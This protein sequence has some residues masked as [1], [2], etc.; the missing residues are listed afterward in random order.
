[1]VEGRSPADRLL[2]TS[3]LVT[4]VAV[5]QDTATALMRLAADVPL[6]RRMGEVGRQRVSAYYQR[7]DM[8]D[9]YR[10]LYQKEVR[11]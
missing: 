2:G 7:G 11:S 8:L 9:A 4:R 5:P 3:G 1:M 6:R 10:A